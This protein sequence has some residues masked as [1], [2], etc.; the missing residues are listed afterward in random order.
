MKLN[1]A[2]A[3]PLA[4]DDNWLVGILQTTTKTKNDVTI[5]LQ[6][7]HWHMRATLVFNGLM[8]EAKLGTFSKGPEIPKNLLFLNQ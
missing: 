2:L 7:Q 4:N 5:Q 8:L 1:L 6:E 3:I